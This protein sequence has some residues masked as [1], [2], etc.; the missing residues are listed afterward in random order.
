MTQNCCRLSKLIN[1]I[2]DLSKIDAG[3]YELSF[4]NNNIVEVV[5]DIVLSVADYIKV[6]GL[7]LIF[8]TEVE[9]KV[10]A[11]DP[12]KIE[13]IVLNL[14]SNAVKFSDP[15][16]DIY[17]NVLDK[18]DFVEISDKD[19][20]IGIDKADMG[21]IFDRFAQADKSLSRNA[22]GTGIGLSI[23]KSFTELHGGKVGV[24]SEFGKGSKFTVTLPARCVENENNLRSRALI[25]NHDVIRMELS[26]I[27]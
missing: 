14:I 7:N 3:F 9:E 5:E 19:N 6:K 11:C 27:I 12:E 24:E 16:N 25:N 4:S 26:D 10:I 23:V 18:G 20:G 2:V 17:I 8:D 15:G 22:E 13:R 1:N 21:V